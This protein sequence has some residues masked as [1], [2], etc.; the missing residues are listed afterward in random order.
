MRVLI[1][2]DDLT[3]C[4][5]LAEVVR[6]WGYEPTVVVD[7]EA[8]WQVMQEGEPPRL[9]LIDWEMPK[10]D[11]LSLC[12]RIRKHESNDPPYLI[13][14]TART[15]TDDIVAGL[16]AGANDYVPKPFAKA[17][18]QARLQTGKRIL[19]LQEQLI[20]DIK[21][22]EDL[23]S[24]LKQSNQD[25]EQTLAELEVLQGVIPICSYCKKIHQ[26]SGG[27]E[28]IEKYVQDHSSAQF[29]H[30]ICPCCSTKIEL[31]LEEFKNRE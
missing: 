11:G 10:L 24:K 18:L 9:L 7:G 13:L 17:E 31:E 28:G 4:T 26:T 21:A 2:D 6:K 30:G 3:T 27:W 25:L 5:I 15:D 23:N 19:V 20:D 29:S 16:E 12:R 14:L 8:A 1:A 22:Q